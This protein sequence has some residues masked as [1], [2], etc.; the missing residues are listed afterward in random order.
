[1]SALIAYLALNAVTGRQG[2]ISYVH[3]QQR[4]HALLAERDELAADSADLRVKIRALADA[5]LD[6][7]A[8]EEE[9][10][11]QI[12]AAAPGEI[13]FDLAQNATAGTP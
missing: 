10:R 9:A 11:R 12:G 6:L 1:L 13:V 3:I 4:E 2:L 7:D 8:L 5:T